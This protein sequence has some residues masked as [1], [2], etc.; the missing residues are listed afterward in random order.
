MQAF[1][2]IEKEIPSYVASAMFVLIS[3]EPKQVV[4]S[5]GSI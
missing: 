5:I 4:I 2:H 3:F 1:I